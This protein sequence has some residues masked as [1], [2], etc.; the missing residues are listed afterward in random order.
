MKTLNNI[1]LA[2]DDPF[3]LK[4]LG[5]LFITIGHNVVIQVSSGRVIMNL[6]YIKQRCLC[7]MDV[8]QESDIQTYELCIQIK[9]QFPAN[10]VVCYSTSND[11]DVIDKMYENGLDGYVTKGTEIDYLVHVVADVS[12]EN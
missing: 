1:A 8:S 6:E 4:E 7:V 12:A 5:N 3:L 10:K 2:I 9:R 11:K